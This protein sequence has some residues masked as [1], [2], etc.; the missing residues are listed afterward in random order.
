MRGEG[1]RR[2][3]ARSEVRACADRRRRSRRRRRE[4]QHRVGQ[5]R[6][7]APALPADRGRRA[8]ARLPA[9]RS[10]A[11]RAGVDVSAST[12]QRPRSSR[13]DAQAD[14]AAADDQQ[15]RSLRGSVGRHGDGEGWPEGNIGVSAAQNRGP[16]L[17]DASQPSRRHARF[18]VTVQPSG[19]PSASSAT[20]RSCRPPSARASACRTAARDGACGSCKCR[21]L[22]G[23]VIHGAHQQQGARAHEEEAPASSSPACAAP[24]T[25]VVLEARTVAGAGE[26]AMRKMPSRV[27]CDRRA[28]ARRRR[29]CSC[30]CRPT[31]LLQYRAGQYVEFILRDGARRSYSMANAPHTAATSRGS[32]CTSATCRAASS[33][34]TSSAAMKEKGHPAHRGPVRQLL[35]AR[36]LRQADGPARLGHRLRADQGDHR[37]PA[38]CKGSERPAVLYWGCRS[39]ADSV[40]ERLGRRQ[41]RRSCRTCATSRCSP[42]RSPRTAGTAAPASSTRR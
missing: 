37:A 10:S 24:Q 33:P 28:R 27:V 13:D 5:R 17:H 34:T 12:R 21:L 4:M 11:T 30:S 20:S 7:G 19:R 6:R 26:F 39:R 9:A 2:A 14:V 23:R 40:H 3:S 15:H 41:R 16:S 8:A 25:D 32:S 35:P 29:C 18:T 22:E 38:V 36:G 1:A 31:T 42:S